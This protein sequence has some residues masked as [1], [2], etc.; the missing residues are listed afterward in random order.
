[1]QIAVYA[2]CA[3]QALEA[4]DGQ[5]ASGDRARCISRSATSASSEG[6]LGDAARAGRDR[7]RGARVASS[8]R[9]SIRSRPASFRRSRC[10]PA[11]VPVVPVR[12]RVPQGISGGGRCS[13]VCLTPIAGRAARPPDQAARDFAVDPAQPRRARGV[14]RHRQDARARRSL[15]P[16]DRGGR[17]SAPHPGD[18]VHAQGGRRDAR[19]RAGRAAPRAAD[20]RA[21]LAERWR[22]LRERIADIQISTIDAF[23][24]GLLREFPL[25]AGVDPAFEIADETEMARFATR[26][27]RPHAARGPRPD[28]RRR[29]RAAAVR[30]RQAAGRCA[31]RSQSLLDR[32]HV[33]LPAVA[34]VRRRARPV[35]DRRG[36]RRGVRRARRAS[37]LTPSPDR[38]AL[39]DD[40]PSSAPEFRWLR[41]DLARSTT[42]PG[43][44]SRPRPAAAAAARAV[45]PDRGAASRAQQVGQRV[46]AERVRVAPTPSGGTTRRSRRSRRDVSAALDA[47]DR[48]RQRPARARA[49]AGAR[50]RGRQIRARCST[51]TRCSISPACSTRA[52]ALLAR[53][54]EFAR[55]RLKLQSRYH[56][57][58]VDEFQDT[59]RAAVAARRAARSTP[60]AKARASPD[61]PT[62]IFVVGDRKQSI[63]RFRHAE[64]TL[65]D[66]AARKIAR[67]CGPGRAC[68]RRSRTAFA[69]C[70]SCWRSSTRCRRGARAADRR[71][72]SASRTATPIAFRCPT[73]ARARGATASRCSAS[74]PSRRWTR[75][76]AGRRGR[77]RSGC[78]DGAL[79]RDRARA[80]GRRGP[81]T[82]R[83]CSAR[84]PGISI[85][86]E[87]LEARGIRTY[88]YKGLGFFD[89][90]E[91]QDL[92]ALLR[93]LAQPDSRP[94]RGRVAAIALRAR[95]PTS[96]LARLA[97]AFA[98]ARS[99]VAGVRRRGVA[100]ARSDAAIARCSIARARAS[101]RW[102]ALADRVTP[103]ELVDRVLRESAYAFELRGRRLDQARENVKKVRAL[104]RRVENRGYATLGRLADYFETLRAGDES[105]ADRRGRRAA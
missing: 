45:L 83:S 93:Y 98:R 3:R 42:F 48:R 33:A 28:R 34:R 43:R 75:C 15:R 46:H 76:A 44:R 5:R 67:A 102:L 18:H 35:D 49:A 72:T 1:M 94:A 50:D 88:V 101:R 38:A 95:C 69:P 80:R 63:Y 19:P 12:G 14:G 29:E 13:R 8:R 87:A 23:C 32:R 21:S 53:Q 62:S 39:L 16:A 91:V 56:H 70:P 103:S 90:P 36:R 60:G 105:N 11:D 31:T 86:E 52:V 54:E 59:S 85:F 4:R 73:S 104:V 40:G 64:V 97:P 81:T 65:L 2:H 41:G 7:R 25:E 82:S 84:G 17:R 30:A 79:V 71:S 99:A 20:G 61:A 6:T 37:C 26:G 27:A 78:S 47:L 100:A 74:S 51:S 92:Q 89:A 68:G 24:F 9:S 10:A 57:V 58:L 96:A 55:S 66:E 77:G 22:E